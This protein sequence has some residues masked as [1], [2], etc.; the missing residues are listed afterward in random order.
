VFCGQFVKK[1]TLVQGLEGMPI[2]KTKSII[3]QHPGQPD[4]LIDV[5]YKLSTSDESS[6]RKDFTLSAYGLP[7]PIDTSTSSN[8]KLYILVA[9]I[10]LFAGGY[11]LR[12]WSRVRNT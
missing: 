8:R 12:R 4:S 6:P 1:S 2:P 3:L 7:E 10:A 9:I 5:K 11:L